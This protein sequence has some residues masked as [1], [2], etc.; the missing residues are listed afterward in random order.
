ML[1]DD[2]GAASH[3]TARLD[4]AVFGGSALTD[5]T[6]DVPDADPG[7]EAIPVTYVPAR[8]TVFLAYALAWGEVLPAYDLFI[9]VNAVDYSGYPDCRPA[10]IEAFERMANQATK[11]GVES[12]AFQIHAPLL[13]LTKGEII[14]RE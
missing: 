6:I 13:H 4:L 7:S 10:F 1:A 12:Q 14:Q 5:E 8:N 2:L 11:A 3:R 9:G